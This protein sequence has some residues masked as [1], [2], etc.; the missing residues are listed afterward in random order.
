MSLV[1]LKHVEP[2]QQL[3]KA[4]NLPQL[5]HGF[6]CSWFTT[7][8]ILG[9]MSGKSWISWIYMQSLKRLELKMWDSTPRYINCP[10]QKKIIPG[11]ETIPKELPSQEWSERLAA[12][13]AGGQAH[14]KCG[15]VTLQMSGWEVQL[16]TSR[17]DGQFN[18]IQPNF[19]VILKKVQ[20]N[21][22]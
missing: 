10:S 18:H 20:R 4:E 5:L 15:M 17:A 19:V 9:L 6:T 21:W 2:K 16:S 1:T 8:T 12:K 7:K 22:I 14:S 3:L 11:S 13:P